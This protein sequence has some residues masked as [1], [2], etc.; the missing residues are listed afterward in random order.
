MYGSV[1]A[2]ESEAAFANYRMWESLGFIIAFAYSNELCTSVKLYILTSILILGWI[3]FAIVEYSIRSAD[4]K[5]VIAQPE[6]HNAPP[7]DVVVNTIYPDLDTMEK[8]KNG[9]PPY[10]NL[11]FENDLQITSTKF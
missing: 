4:K 8:K 3:G 10:D 11:G 7:E 2:D 9:P 5:K 6:A 1:F